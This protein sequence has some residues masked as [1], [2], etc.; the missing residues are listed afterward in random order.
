MADDS[1]APFQ[2]CIDRMNAGDPSARDEL[3]ERAGARLERLAH[4]MLQDFPRVRRWE[5]TV[6]VLQNAVLRL[7]QALRIEKIG[8][9]REFFRLAA[10]QIRRE[11][12]DLVRHHYGPQGMGANQATGVQ[13]GSG[14]AT[15]PPFGD[16]SDSTF[17]PAKLAAWTQFHEQ[18][19]ALPQEER[20]VFD[21][22][23]YQDLTQAQAGAVLHVS[24]ATVKR[25][26]LS[27][28]LRLL[29]ALKTGLD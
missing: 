27:A 18:V 1:G 8:S 3:L 6:D 14:Q 10:L 21:L 2:S 20:D 26:W 17:D 15:P 9:A 25:R 12:L 5:D 16:R 7:L 28:R 11:L 4:K 19:E 29:P 24:V 23:W 22:L 13:A